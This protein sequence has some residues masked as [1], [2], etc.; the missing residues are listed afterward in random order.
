MLVESS[1]DRPTGCS[2]LPFELLAQ[3]FVYVTHTLSPGDLH[4]TS[5]MLVCRKWYNVVINTPALWI[6]I[7]CH[8]IEARW[9]ERLL[10]LSQDLPISLRVL[11]NNN[12]Y[13]RTYNSLSVFHCLCMSLVMTTSTDITRVQEIHIR[14]DVRQGGGH[15]NLEQS[16]ACLRQSFPMLHTFYLSARYYAKELDPLLLGGLA[17]KLRRFTLK[18]QLGTPP[19][20][21]LLRHL[22][23]LH[24]DFT[25]ES[26]SWSVEETLAV[27]AASPSLTS[28]A[29]VGVVGDSPH[30]SIA[31]PEKP[32]VLPLRLFIFDLSKMAMRRLTDRLVSSRRITL[33][34]TMSTSRTPDFVYGQFNCV[35]RDDPLSSLFVSLSMGGFRIIDYPASANPLL[36]LRYSRAFPSDRTDVRYFIGDRGTNLSTIDNVPRP[37]A[38]DIFIAA[39]LLDVPDETDFL[40]HTVD[41]STH[42]LTDTVRWFSINVKTTVS[43]I[44]HE[45]TWRRLFLTM[46]LVDRLSIRIEDRAM[47][48][49]LAALRSRPSSMNDGAA[50]VLPRLRTLELDLEFG[51][52]FNSVPLSANVLNR[53]KEEALEYFESGTF[54]LNLSDVLDYRRERSAPITSVRLAYRYGDTLGFVESE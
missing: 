30:N 45:E 7:A 27:L 44:M 51:G 34:G 32:V 12:A 25:S 50:V 31:Y 36:D 41:I 17:P 8:H 47:E 43:P 11:K 49:M 10:S 54:R 2:S 14:D 21:P 40:S 26:R 48:S 28:L 13:A 42:S 18:T 6:T 24:L 9:I 46:P 37:F 5:V 33:N 22:T 20:S 16:L 3:I 29:L 39:S 35:D 15:L 53:R 38:F 4:W 19:T 52:T 1:P 23:W